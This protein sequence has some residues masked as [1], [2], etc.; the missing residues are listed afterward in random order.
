MQ[1]AANQAKCV[2]RRRYRAWRNSRR[3]EVRLNDAS[4]VSFRRVTI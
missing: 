1:G 2:E 4:K 3:K